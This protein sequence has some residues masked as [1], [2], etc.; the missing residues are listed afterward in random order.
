MNVTAI[1][2]HKY[3]A[4]KRKL[5]KKKTEPSLKDRALEKTKQHHEEI[6]QK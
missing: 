4:L 3:F 6:N 1:L 2:V 5:V